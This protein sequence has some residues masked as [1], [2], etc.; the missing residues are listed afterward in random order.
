MVYLPT[1]KYPDPGYFED[2]TPASYRFFHPSI[3][4]S[5]DP[6]GTFIDFSWDQCR[7]TYVYQEN[8]EDVLGCVT[9]RLHGTGIFT[10]I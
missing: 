4:G 1:Q 3:G 8:Q 5:N 9:H 6:Y 10:Y 2:P 7:Q